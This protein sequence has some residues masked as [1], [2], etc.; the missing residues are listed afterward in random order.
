MKTIIVPTDFS[1]T[2]FSAARYAAALAEKLNTTL[3]LFHAFP[4]PLT[5]SEVPVPP[6]VFNA[7]QKD[8][9]DFIEQAKKDLQA[10]IPAGLIIKTTIRPGSLLTGLHEL[11]E[12]TEPYAVVMSSHGNTGLEHF[13]LGSETISTL[14][15]LPWPL[16]IVPHGA[17][18]KSPERILLSCDLEDVKATVPANVIK[19]LVNT[20]DAQLYVLHVHDSH[21]KPYNDEVMNGTA[22][23]QE[24]LADLHPS[25]HFT[26]SKDITETIL[27][28]VETNEIDLVIGFPKKRNLLENLF[29]KSK[30][31]AIA[32]ETFVPFFAFHEK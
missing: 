21:D 3:T 15:H 19:D 8:A 9:E 30:S 18:F 6:Q 12:E 22:D 17:T 14:R 13:L 24:M 28:F 20:F 11:C 32:E 29:H 7:L 27:R 31:K 16:I 5:Y 2:A 4:M 1:A 10:V 23:L 26:D 25:F